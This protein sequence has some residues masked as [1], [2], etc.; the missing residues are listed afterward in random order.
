MS[1]ALGAKRALANGC[2]HQPARWLGRAGARAKVEPR[3]QRA[4]QP[5]ARPAAGRRRSSGTNPRRRVFDCGHLPTGERRRR[6]LALVVVRVGES[7]GIP[8]RR[9]RRR[10]EYLSRRVYPKLGLHRGVG[11]G[12]APRLATR[13]RRR[14]RDEG[15]KKK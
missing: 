15:E 6:A 9:L 10:V 14:E 11:G 1:M 8:S 3:R 5:E 2:G 12:G 7:A 13:G 4:R